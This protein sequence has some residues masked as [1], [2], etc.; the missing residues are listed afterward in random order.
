MK[1]AVAALSLALCAA[2]ALLAA[3]ALAQ[4]NSPYNTSG[5]QAGGPLAGQEREMGARGGTPSMAPNAGGRAMA[6]PTRHN[7]KAMKRRNNRM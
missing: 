5:P 7:R 3:P 1:F 6:K 2:P 4:G